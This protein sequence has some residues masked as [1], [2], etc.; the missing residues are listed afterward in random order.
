VECGISSLRRP[1]PT[2]Y[3]AVWLGCLGI[4]RRSTTGVMTCRAVGA[5][6]VGRLTF[7]LGHP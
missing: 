5:V 1:M 2:G 7:D 6:A 4:S 3:L